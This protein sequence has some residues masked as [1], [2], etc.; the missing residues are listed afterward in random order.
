MKQ[1]YR[2]HTKE[3]GKICSRVFKIK[4]NGNRYLMASLELS[5][6][7]LAKQVN[8][9]GKFLKKLY[10]PSIEVVKRGIRIGIIQLGDLK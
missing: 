10:S 4:K 7:E 2:C 5:H 3:N 6:Y 8:E 9:G 1:I